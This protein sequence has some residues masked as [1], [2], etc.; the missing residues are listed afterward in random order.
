MIE[1]SHQN[2]IIYTNQVKCICQVE[3]EGNLLEIQSILG[4]KFVNIATKV[5]VLNKPAQYSKKFTIYVWW[6][7]HNK[8]M[9]ITFQETSHSYFKQYQSTLGLNISLSKL[10]ATI[11]D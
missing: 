1:V 10:W 6:W 2:T 11:G 7:E 8:Y 5:V 9:K 4:K 3:L